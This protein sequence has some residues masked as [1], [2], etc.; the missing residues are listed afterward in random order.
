M[1]AFRLGMNNIA[2][3]ITRQRLLIEGFYKR[4]IGEVQVKEYLLSLA[5]KLSLRTYGSP[6][7]HAPGGTGKQENEGYDAFLPLIDS[8]I[9]TYIWTK[10]KFFCSRTI[11]LQKL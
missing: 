10:S 6:I 3:Q 8:G 1:E 5:S 4:D 2:P 9:S 7:V 11:Y